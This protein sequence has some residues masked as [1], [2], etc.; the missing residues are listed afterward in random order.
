M[1]F[2]FILFIFF[3]FILLFVSCLV[4]GEIFEVGEFQ[5]SN[6]GEITHE[7][8]IRTQ[9][10]V[11]RAG[12]APRL[13]T[14]LSLS[15]SLSIY[16]SISRHDH[17]TTHIDVLAINHVSPPITPSVLGSS[18]LAEVMARPRNPHEG[19]RPLP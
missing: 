2:Y 13:V 4:A 14:S 12:S 19:Q 18:L 15:L 1:V 3:Y 11:T 10:K 9:L 8:F 5:V 17:F 16:L 6:L 7:G